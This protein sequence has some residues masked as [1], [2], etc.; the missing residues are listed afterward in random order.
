MI[1]SR[2]LGASGHGFQIALWVRSAPGLRST[3][4]C[5]RGGS[6]GGRAF[7]ADPGVT[8]PDVAQVSPIALPAASWPGGTWPAE[9]ASTLD[10]RA[11]EGSTSAGRCANLEGLRLYAEPFIWNLMWARHD[12]S[13]PFSWAVK[14]GQQKQR[15][16]RPCVRGRWE[17]RGLMRQRGRC[18]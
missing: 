2:R 4:Y 16:P 15:L 3:E 9:S 11:M 8:S 6:A 1:L 7:T 13:S 10:R 14:G 5:H 17:K 12:R 18:S